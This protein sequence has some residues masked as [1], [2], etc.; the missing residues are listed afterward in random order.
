MIRRLLLALSLLSCAAIA[1]PAPPTP[2]TPPTPPAPPALPTLPELPSLP[3]VPATPPPPEARG[4]VV[5][6]A[7]IDLDADDDSAAGVVVGLGFFAMVVLLF[8]LA[9]RTRLLREERLHETLRAALERGVDVDLSGVLP[10]PRDDRRRGILLVAVGLG[11]AGCALV[12]DGV[13]SA[14]FG[15][16]PGVAG[17]GYLLVHTLERR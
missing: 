5:V 3:A 15:L 10:A 9:Q 7:D 14:A 2:P 17:L 4:A 16:V 13:A 6:D 1:A 12:V 8:G 11:V